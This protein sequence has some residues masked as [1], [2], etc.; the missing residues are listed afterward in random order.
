MSKPLLYGIFVIKFVFGL[1][2]IWWTIAMT[3]SSDVGEDEDNAFLS[4]YHDV[5][6]NFNTMIIDNAKFEAKYKVV[7]YFN[8]DK[9]DGLTI[10]DVYLGQRAIK[11]RKERGDILNVGKNNFKYE[12]TTLDGKKVENVKLNMLVTM[13]TNHKYDKKLEFKNNNSENFEI[14]KKGYWNITGTVGVDSNKGY[15]FIKT[16]AN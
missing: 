4:T 11:S 9:I 1:G 6:D 14:V 16:N 5:N 3:L 15:F 8:N 7:F 2:L 12:I 10:K 13:T